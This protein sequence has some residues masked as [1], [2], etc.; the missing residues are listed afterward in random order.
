MTSAQSV[1]EYVVRGI[2]QERLGAY[3]VHV[4]IG[5]DAATHRWRSD[6]RENIY[7]VSKGVCALA[8]GMAVDEGIARL[9]DPVADYLPS[10]ELGAGVEAVTLRHLLT[11][12]SGIDFE[13]FGNQPAPWPDL[14]Q[15]MLRRPS[16]GRVFHYSD[17]STYVAMRALGARVGDVR[18]WLMP[19]LF[20][21]LEIHNPQWH[22]CPQGWIVGGSGLELR[23]EELA[24][25]GRVLREESRDRASRNSPSR[26]SPADGHPLAGA[27][28]GRTDYRTATKTL[29]VRMPGWIES[30][31]PSAASDGT[32][33]AML[34]LAEP[35]GYSVVEMSSASGGRVADAYP[36]MPTPSAVTNSTCT[37]A[38]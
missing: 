35:P 3:G 6:E 1:L 10:L 7:S 25:I 15:E 31:P 34:P 20:D 12:T 17:A 22:R 2:E 9:D 16:A 27:R 13:W 19:R 14:A 24:R 4:L 8:M 5:D 18:D 33:K 37:S 11:M 38:G 21:P 30:T 36:S 29:S 32:A 26:H 23:T 28:R